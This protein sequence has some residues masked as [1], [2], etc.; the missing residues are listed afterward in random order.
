[1]KTKK[2]RSNF[3]NFGFRG[4]FLFLSRKGKLKMSISYKDG[5]KPRKTEVSE[6]VSF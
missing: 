1:M 5:A 2:H 4:Y 6:V 3:G